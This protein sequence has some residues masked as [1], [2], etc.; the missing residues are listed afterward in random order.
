M[1][2]KIMSDPFT[3]LEFEALSFDDGGFA[4]TNPISGEK[5]FARYDFASDSFTIPA[6]TFRHVDLM[7]I[8]QAAKASGVTV[9]AISKA[10][11]R[12]KIPAKTLSNGKRMIAR[13][14]LDKYN[15]QKRI[16]RPRRDN[17]DA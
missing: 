12:G 9:Q 2:L 6:H 11:R 7:S 13:C 15:E 17:E 14:D 3:G 10:V 16:G 5:V 1:K 4:V 8:T